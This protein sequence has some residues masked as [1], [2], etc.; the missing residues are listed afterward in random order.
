MEDHNWQRICPSA[1]ISNHQSTI[2]M[3]YHY[4]EMA[5][6]GNAKWL[7]ASS[8]QSNLLPRRLF[9]SPS[10]SK[11]P[12]Y[13]TQAGVYRQRYP[14]WAPPTLSTTIRALAGHACFRTISDLHI[15]A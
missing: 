6:D 1:T 12:V 7:R 15:A 2:H 11:R 14:R 5:K 8:T 9:S 3:I 10:L 4:A 13:I